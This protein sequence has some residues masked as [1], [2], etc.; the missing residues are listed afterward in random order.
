MASVNKVTLIGNLGRDPELR[1]TPSG[2][3]VVSFSMATTEKFKDKQGQ[4]QEQT[5]WHNIVAWEKTAEIMSQYL[6]KGSSVYIEGKL[7]TQSWED[8]GVKKYRTEILVQ[9]FQFLDSKPQDQQQQSQGGF[10]GGQQQQPQQNQGFSGQQQQGF[11]DNQQN[12]GFPQQ[13]QQG[14]NNQSHAQ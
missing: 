14:Y 13:Q 8:N 3:A 4:Q 11:Q 10:G 2:S 9:Q 12:M 6:K 5:E 7:K 1:K